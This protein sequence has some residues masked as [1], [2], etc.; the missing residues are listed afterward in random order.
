MVTNKAPCMR[1]SRWSLLVTIPLL[2][3]GAALL[4]WGLEVVRPGMLTP[5]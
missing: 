4:C 1:C 2:P 3:V 5:C